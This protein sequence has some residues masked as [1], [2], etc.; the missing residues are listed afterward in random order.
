MA[1]GLDLTGSKTLW[2]TLVLA[3]AILASG[4][5]YTPDAQVRNAVGQ[6]MP[7]DAAPAEQQVFRFLNAEPTN[8]DIGVAI[9]E[10]GGI[11][12]LFERLTMLDHNNEVVPGAAQSWD[13]SD[14]QT[15][16]TFHMRPGGKWSDG[17]PVTAH[18][19]EYAFKRMLNPATG[20]SYAFFYYDIK[21]SR[22][23]NTGKA[24]N[25]DGVGIQAM[26]DLT[27]V[28]ETEGPCP[29]LPMIAAFFTSNPVP[30]W[31]VEKYGD[32]WAKDENIISNSSYKVSKWLSGQHLEFQLDAMYNGP[33][34]GFFST[35]RSIFFQNQMASGLLPYENDE[36]D[37]AQIDVRDLN[38]VENDER[39][40]AELHLFMDFNALY[41]FFQTREGIFSDKR[42][43]RAIGHAID[44]DVL[45]N[46]VLR[47][48]ALPAYTMIPPGFPGYAGDELKSIQRFDVTEAKRLLA[49]AGY[50][51][52]RGFP[53]TEI[54]LRGDL[55][56]RVMASEAI[57]AM[58]KEN[59]N[60]NV[61]VQ[62]MEARSYNEKMLQF[63][64]PLSLIPFQYDFPDQHNLLGMVWHTQAK[65]V[66]RHDWTNTEFDALI[67]GAARETDS[68]LRRRMYTDAER[69]LIED[70]GGVFVFHDYV[71]QLRKPWLGGW[72]RD[73]IGQEPFFIDNTTITD[74]YIKRH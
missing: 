36:L 65:G 8:L 62:N 23:Y 60:I 13:S 49:D 3:G 7:A 71:L 68:D 19:F 42:I 63:E 24:A 50:P 28:I 27:L 34:K 4:Y 43:R 40:N 55:P 57:A 59:L 51:G 48:N 64:V 33:N 17:R 22:G 2:L 9:Y 70:A 12:F 5:W 37:L 16:W 54:W 10:V 30:R 11:V 47:G 73:S 52:G 45:C 35:I 15:R 74:L 53:S 29:Y 58:L 6:L 32:H 25:A 61:S 44:R 38:R 66:G 39:L 69:I 41:L 46:V 31:Q 72:K 14:N 56:H 26:D 20:S 21:G 18:D 1:H 67:D